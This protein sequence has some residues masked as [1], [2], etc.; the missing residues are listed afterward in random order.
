MVVK[1]RAPAQTPASLSADQCSPHSRLLTAEAQTRPPGPFDGTCETS[2]LVEAIA[3]R[4]AELVMERQREQDAALPTRPMTV[5]EVAALFERSHEWVR[6]RRAE[7]GV[8]ERQGMRPR[9][10]FDPSRVRQALTARSPGKRSEG[11]E[12]LATKPKTRRRKG[13]SMGTGGSLL[14]IGRA[15]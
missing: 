8:I 2:E 3:Q 1:E 13:S 4:T 9:L 15:K 12:S 10:E 11:A 5:A 14:P 6:D 7:L